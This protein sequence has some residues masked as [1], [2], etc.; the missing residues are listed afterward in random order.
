[1]SRESCWAKQIH[2]GL[3]LNGLLNFFPF[4]PGQHWT[5]LG[6]LVAQSARGTPLVISYPKSGR[7][8]LRVMLDE[9][10]VDAQYTHFGANLSKGLPFEI[11]RAKPVWCAFRPTLLLIRDPLDTLVSSFFQATRRRSVFTGSISEFLRDPRFGIEK[12]ARWNLMWSEL[13]LPRNRFSIIQYE[14]FHTDVRA[15]LMAAAEALGAAPPNEADLARASAA[16]HID[17][18]RARER[19]GAYADQY[20]YR[21]TPIDPSDAESFKVRRGQIGGYRD[22]LS[23]DDMVY[24]EDVLSQL[25]YKTRLAASFAF[26][27][28]GPRWGDRP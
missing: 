3:S 11:L 21:L 7:T 6:R 26:R 24:C 1:M 19:S 27:G 12:L 5:Q 22:Y 8:W 2:T 9:L 23:P 16:G 4:V 13:T 28:V 18:M 20:G 10:G 25:A 14:S 17:V 15:A